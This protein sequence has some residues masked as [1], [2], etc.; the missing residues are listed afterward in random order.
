MKAGSAVV[1]LTSVNAF[2]G[3]KSSP[4]Y[5]AS[6]GV[7][8]TLTKYF[9]VKLSE[10]GIRVNAVAPGFIE[11]TGFTQNIP[12]E[13]LARFRKNSSPLSVIISAL[14]KFP[15]LLTTVNVW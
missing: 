2:L 3:G 7:A 15:E 1:N 5:P 11:G 6:N 4:A 8:N 14:W 12:A 9:A 13:K 10:K